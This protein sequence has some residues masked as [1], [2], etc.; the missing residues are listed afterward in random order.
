MPGILTGVMLSIGRSIGETA[1][2]I[3]TAGSSLRLPTS[4]FDSSRTMAVHFYILA[5][6]GISIENA[7]GTAAVL[8]LSVL[9]VNLAAYWTDESIYC[10]ELM[11]S[12]GYSASKILGAK[13]ER[14]LRATQSLKIAQS[15]CP[16]QQDPRH[17]RPRGIRQNDVSAHAEP[18]ERSLPQLPGR[19]PSAAAT[20]RTSTG[21]DS[22][23]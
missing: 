5:R 3:F 12:A 21:R 22:T 2:V 1:A 11:T 16:G 15:R 4:L 14:L 18:A 9:L 6:E 19:G 8:I 10:E 13:S 17:H 20:A 7:Y 23:S